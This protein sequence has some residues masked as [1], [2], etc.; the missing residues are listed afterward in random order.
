LTDTTCFYFHPT[1]AEC[2]HV[3][4][5]NITEEVRN[6]FVRFLSSGQ[7]VSLIEPDVLV[8]E[9]ARD[10]RW[11]Y[12]IALSGADALHVASAL[13]MEC[14]EFLTTDKKGPLNNA[15]KIAALKMMVIKP[16]ATGL[17]SD[18]RRRTRIAGVPPLPNTE[19][20]V[21]KRNGLSSSCLVPC[22]SFLSVHWRATSRTYQTGRCQRFVVRRGVLLSLA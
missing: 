7:Y 10:L 17:L 12:G 5:E 9:D 16:S 19:T 14:N 20:I 1:I 8:A 3:G 15:S 21:E 4:D 22:R 11:K 18:E 13:S 2:T 6:L